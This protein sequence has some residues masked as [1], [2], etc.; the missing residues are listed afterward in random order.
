MTAVL[1]E[2]MSENNK[3]QCTLEGE[4]FSCYYKIMDHCFEKKREGK[5]KALLHENI[6]LSNI[7]MQTG[8]V[9]F[10]FVPVNMQ[11]APD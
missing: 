5:K 1:P 4:A 2:L 6:A 7:K 10:L 3:R 9:W 8:E 11:I